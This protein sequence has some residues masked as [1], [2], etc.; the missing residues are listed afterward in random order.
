MADARALTLF[1]TGALAMGNAVA[2]L[3]FARFWRRTGVALFGWFAVAFVLLALQRLTL[4][5]IE[6]SPGS[7][8][9]SHVVRLVAFLLILVG[10]WA[11]NRAPR[12]AARDAPPGAR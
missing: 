12:S 11:Q 6:R 4:V 9:W 2:A 1:V 7:M 3:F 5:L 10:V 8:P